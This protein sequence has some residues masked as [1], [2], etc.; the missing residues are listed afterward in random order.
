MVFSLRGDEAALVQEGKRRP[1][2]AS[3]S[4]VEEV[5]GGYWGDGGTDR[6]RQQ[7]P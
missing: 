1:S 3:F 2:G 7:W 5:A 6:R 4:H